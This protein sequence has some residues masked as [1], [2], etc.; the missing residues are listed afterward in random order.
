[1]VPWFRTRIM[2]AFPSP[3]LILRMPIV[4]KVPRSIPAVH[5]VV[6]S[7]TMDP[8][9]CDV[10]Q[11]IRMRMLHVCQQ[12]PSRHREQFLQ[13]SPRTRSEDRSSCQ[14]STSPKAHGIATAAMCSLVVYEAVGYTPHIPLF[15]CRLNRFPTTCHCPVHNV[16]VQGVDERL[17]RLSEQCSNFAVGAG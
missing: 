4:E 13:C 17:E 6:A 2:R 16:H 9:S 8:Q 7:Q 5:I 14:S 12:T 10:V 15:P 1:M 3:Q 11:A